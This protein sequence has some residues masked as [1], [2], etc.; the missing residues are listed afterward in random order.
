MLLSRLGTPYFLP[1]QHLLKLRYAYTDNYSAEEFT[2]VLS[3][4]EF[5]FRY[6][7]G[8]PQP[9]SRIDFADKEK[10]VSDLSLH[11]SVLVSLAELEQLHRGLALQNFSSLMHS[12]PK[13]FSPL[14]R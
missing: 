9:T 13:V 8:F 7:S 14:S 1:L 10:V 5:D 12:H 3:S 4:D 2:S 11:Y 6:Q